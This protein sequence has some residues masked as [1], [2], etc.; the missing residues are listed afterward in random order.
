MGDDVEQTL[1][2]LKRRLGALTDQGLADRLRLGR[3]TVTSWRRRGA[4]P[5]RYSR[6]AQ[7]V[8]AFPPDLLDP[9]WTPVEH[10]AM[11]LALVRLVK[12][13]GDELK[14]FPHF[15]TN[16]GFLTP[17]L[18]VGVEHALLDLTARM[19][20]SGVEDPTQCLTL[21][22]YEEFFAAK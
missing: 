22:V 13:I 20:E 9:S 4:V 14:D 6:L 8:L 1:E 10:A 2:A 21:I 12:G 5:E 19:T 17:R 3:S 15:L 7:E 18:A 16:H 11:T